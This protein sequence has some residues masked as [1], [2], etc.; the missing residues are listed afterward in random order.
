MI[1]NIVM[2][3][4]RTSKEVEFM[5]DSK[6]YIVPPGDAV[7]MLRDAAM[8]GVNR[9]LFS[10]NTVTGITKSKLGIEGEHDTKD[11]GAKEIEREGA[12]PKRIAASGPISNAVDGPRTATRRSCTHPTHRRPRV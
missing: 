11:L 6:V 10:W 8:H 12:T 1:G 7:P 5:H 4:N 9:C 3:K 2:L